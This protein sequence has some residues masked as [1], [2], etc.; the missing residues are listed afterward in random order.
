MRICW[1][2]LKFARHQELEPV[3]ASS[4]WGFHAQTPALL[5]LPTITTLS[6]SFLA[7]IMLYRVQQKIKFLPHLEHRKTNQTHLKSK[8]L[9]QK[10]K[11]TR[12]QFNVI[13]S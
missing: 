2:K 13:T 5:L 6:S 10:L 12:L 9:L 7:L 4:D 8:H 1:K 3:L 11:D